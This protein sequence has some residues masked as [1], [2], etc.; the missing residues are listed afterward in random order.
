[1][2]TRCSYSKKELAKD[3]GYTTKRLTKELIIFESELLEEFPDYSRNSQILRPKVYKFLLDKIGALEPEDIRLI[4]QQ[5]AS[6]NF[7]CL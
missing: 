5:K 3:I 7:G 4:M 1:M 2:T 6:R